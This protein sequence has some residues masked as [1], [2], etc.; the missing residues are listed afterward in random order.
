MEPLHY[1]D[2]PKT[3]AECWELLGPDNHGP[4]IQAFIDHGADKSGDEL[5]RFKKV[6]LKLSGAA[7]IPRLFDAWSADRKV[8][9]PLQLIDKDKVAN[10]KG[11]FVRYWLLT[12]KRHAICAVLDAAGIP[13]DNGYIR[14]DY[15]D[16]TP[17]VW[18]KGLPTLWQ[19]E[20]LVVR[21]YLG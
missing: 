16:A 21:L 12:Y 4:A 8:T 20:E 3:S 19:Q 18:K 2:L 10:F 5:I 9:K 13:N 1:D 6:V 17:E 11:N 14:D 7:D 15:K